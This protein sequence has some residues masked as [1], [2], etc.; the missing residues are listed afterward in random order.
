MIVGTKMGGKSTAGTT[1]GKLTVKGKS[2][3]VD[4]KLVVNGKEQSSGSVAVGR[5][6]TYHITTTLPNIG[7]DG[8]AVSVHI[9]DNMVGRSSSRWTASRSADS[10]STRTR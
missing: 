6:A 1:L 5:T 3:N 7:N 8:S 2:Y 9:V 10:R 4:K